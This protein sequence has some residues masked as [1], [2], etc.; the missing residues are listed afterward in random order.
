LHVA[1]IGL[2]D[3][4]FRSAPGVLGERGCHLGVRPSLIGFLR[5]APPK[6]T[7]YKP[8]HQHE[9]AQRN[10]RLDQRDDDIHKLLEQ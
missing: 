7:A 4:C 2:F 5:W 9:R 8:A 6:E 1:F 3:G 10:Y